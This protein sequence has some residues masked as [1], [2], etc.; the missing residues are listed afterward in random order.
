[1]S[2]VVYASL[3]LP[4]KALRRCPSS[5]WHSGPTLLLKQ[6]VVYLHEPQMKQVLQLGLPRTRNRSLVCHI[7]WCEG[8]TGRGWPRHQA[9][10][11]A[12]QWATSSLTRLS[13]VHI[14]GYKWGCCAPLMTPLWC[15]REELFEN[16]AGIMDASVLRS[17]K[18]HKGSGSNTGH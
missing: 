13:G 11:S 4:R 1:M 16:A 18:F 7:P 5:R 12:P 8:L 15:W 6:T 2:R 10:E 3:K 17:L 9:G 14:V